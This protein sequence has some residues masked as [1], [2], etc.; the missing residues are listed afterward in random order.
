MTRERQIARLRDADILITQDAEYD[1]HDVLRVK[2]DWATV[3]PVSRMG[4]D[5]IQQTMIDAFR[6]PHRYRSD[7]EAR[8]ILK[9]ATKLRWVDEEDETSFAFRVPGEIFLRNHVESMK[10]WGLHVDSTISP[11]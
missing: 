8:R 6:G 10:D 7:L 5:Y 11:V 4:Q 1:E 2:G 3:E 9:T